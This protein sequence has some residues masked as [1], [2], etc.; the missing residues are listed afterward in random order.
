MPELLR[1]PRRVIAEL[2]L[3]RFEERTEWPLAAAAAIFL[4]AYSVEVLAQPQG[5]FRLA[6][7]L[8]IDITYA[9]FV[10]DY[11]RA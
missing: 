3:E 5:H 11:M 6:M 2:T 10:V 1:V 7:E 9:L 8:V 4:A